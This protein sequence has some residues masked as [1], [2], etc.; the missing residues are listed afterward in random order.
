ML[1]QHLH[2]T[3]PGRGCQVYTKKA[4]RVGV[5]GLCYAVFRARVGVILAASYYYS[6]KTSKAAPSGA[7]FLP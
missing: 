1:I 6:I 7:A 4:Q 3:P 5:P 2:D